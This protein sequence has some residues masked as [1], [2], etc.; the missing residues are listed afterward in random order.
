MAAARAGFTLTHLAEQAPHTA[1]AARFPR[2][3]KYV[4]WPMLVVLRLTA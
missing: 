3:Q 1:F 2:A 4:G